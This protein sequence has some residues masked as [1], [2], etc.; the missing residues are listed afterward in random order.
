[1]RRSFT[2]QNSSINIKD[3]R[4]IAETVREV[5]KN[6][7]KKLFKNCSKNI[8]H[9]TVRE[10]TKDSKKKLYNYTATNANN[11]IK[12]K[13]KKI[14]GEG[15]EMCDFE[16]R[17]DPFEDNKSSIPC[18]LKTF[19]PKYDRF[20]LQYSNGKFLCSFSKSETIECDKKENAKLYYAKPYYAQH[21]DR[22]LFHL[23]NIT[24]LPSLHLNIKHE[25][26]QYSIFEYDDDHGFFIYMIL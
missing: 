17:D 7:A 16:F 26:K 2:I 14:G 6:I 15:E 5:A 22:L 25:N 13:S 11:T 4:F 19:L 9:F 18:R 23:I 1:M 8:I 12:I 3:G 10:T 21:I 24:Q 20:Y